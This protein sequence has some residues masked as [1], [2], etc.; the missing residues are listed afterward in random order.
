MVFHDC[1]L[2]LTD[3]EFTFT[4]DDFRANEPDSSNPATFLPVLVSKSIRI[5]SRVELVVVPLTVDEAR[6]SS[7]PLPPNIPDDDQRSPPFASK[8]ST[9]CII[10]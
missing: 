10:K 2:F 8:R 7:L 1:P 4:E 6:A 5:A 9:G 3:V